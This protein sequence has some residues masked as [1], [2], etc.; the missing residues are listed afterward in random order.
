MK[1]FK[2][3]R[4]LIGSSTFG[5]VDRSPL[6]HLLEMGCEIIRNPYKRKLT[7]EEVI[8][9]LSDN[10]IGLIA[11]LEPLDREVLEKTKLKVISRCGSGLSNIDLDIA[12][13]LGIKVCS[14]PFGPITAVAELT[15]GAMLSLLRWIPQMN[16]EMHEGKWIKKIG[17]QLEG[18]TVVIIGFGRIGRKVASLLKHFNA[19][20]IAVDPNIHKDPEGIEILPLDRALPIADIISIHSNGENQI[21]GK[22]EF[23]LIKQGAFLLNVARGSLVDEESLIEVLE[24]GKIR[25]AWIDTFDPEPYIGKLVN[26]P[27]VILTPHIGSY[28][29]ECRRA[30][31]MEAV[32]N[33]ISAFEEMGL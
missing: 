1:K 20:I 7:K 28:T 6:N 8:D 29:I 13:E 11:G 30:M 15:V 26:Y 14:T 33:L 17:L 19:R 18:K 4:V 9:L 27:Q 12:N 24:S 2:D 5:A 3:I 31:E 16:N 22:N 10:V 25:G 21:I 32:N 23:G